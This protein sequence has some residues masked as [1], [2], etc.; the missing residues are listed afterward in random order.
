MKLA[1]ASPRKGSVSV[2]ATVANAGVAKPI[3]NRSPPATANVTPTV[4]MARMRSRAFTIARIS[5]PTPMRKT[6]R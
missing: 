6:G 2:P 4:R 1:T 3:P 5:S